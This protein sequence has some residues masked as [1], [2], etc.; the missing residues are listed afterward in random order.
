MEA[1]V[2]PFSEFASNREKKPDHQNHADERQRS[3]DDY[4]RYGNTQFSSNHVACHRQDGTTKSGN[5][6]EENGSERVS[7]RLVRPEPV[8]GEQKRRNDDT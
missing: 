5:L 2:N 3:K 1:L 7:P 4:L 6:H 8:R